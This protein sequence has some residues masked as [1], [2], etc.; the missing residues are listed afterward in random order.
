MHL[1]RQQLL[2][3][4][5]LGLCHE[6]F[7][8]EFAGKPFAVSF[9]KGAFIELAM[10]SGISLIKDRALYK[11]LEF[12]EEKKLLLYQNKSLSLTSRGWKLFERLRRTVDPFVKIA[13]TFRSQNIS[14][15]TKK[16]RTVLSV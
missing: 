15:Y 9:S 8:K 2:I 3:L 7:Q 4:Y 5:A 11:N 16:T 12:F 10:R 6:H 14:H 13:D 1:N